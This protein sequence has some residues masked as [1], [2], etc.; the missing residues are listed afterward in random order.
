MN[1]QV[2]SIE[3]QS[4]RQSFTALNFASAEKPSVNSEC[5]PKGGSPG[6]SVAVLLWHT[7]GHL[8]VSV[9]SFASTEESQVPPT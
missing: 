2:L 9:P 4:H 8:Q 6:S 7:A 5:L 3:N 1:L